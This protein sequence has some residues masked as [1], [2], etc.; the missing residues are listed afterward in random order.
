[1]WC[2]RCILRV[3]NCVSVYLIKLPR[4]VLDENL[5][6]D[7]VEFGPLQT[8]GPN[9]AAAVGSWPVWLQVQFG[10][11]LPSRC[12]G[13]QAPLPG[14]KVAVQEQEQQTADPHLQQILQQELPRTSTTVM[15][16]TT[17]AIIR[18]WVREW[19]EQG[20]VL[21]VTVSELQSHIMKEC[22]IIPLPRLW[23]TVTHS[24]TEKNTLVASLNCCW[25]WIPFRCYLP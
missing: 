19:I 7:N 12:P 18:P 22:P 17:Q 11:S 20:E 10:S 5:D 8:T 1:M 25:E 6:P 13:L 15:K 23:P 4:L 2:W 16:A 14:Q 3:L 24:N 21:Y 9:S